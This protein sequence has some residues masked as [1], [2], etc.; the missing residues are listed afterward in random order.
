[1]AVTARGINGKG[2][3]SGCNNFLNRPLDT[4]LTVEIPREL[5]YNAF[6][7]IAAGFLIM[8]GA[9]V[10]VHPNIDFVGLEQPISLNMPVGATGGGKCSYKNLFILGVLINCFC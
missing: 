4:E 3:C 10:P 7:H 6:S 1:M 5:S 9:I 8:I 2:K